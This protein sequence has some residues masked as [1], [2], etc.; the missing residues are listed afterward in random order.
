MMNREMRRKYAKSIKNNKAA[1]ECPICK[2]TSLFKTI[3]REGEET[4]IVCECCN[5]VV[6]QSPQVT[7]TVPPGIY[8]P[9]KL[10]DFTN[11]IAAA[12]QAQ[13]EEADSTPEEE[14]NE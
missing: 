5:A 3:K 4:A 10:N 8:L 6:M 1:C 12:A 7:A 13:A 14:V 11:F 9:L 2:H